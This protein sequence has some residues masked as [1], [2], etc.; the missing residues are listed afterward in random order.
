[1]L[2]FLETT[3]LQRTNAMNQKYPVKLSETERTQ[4]KQLI[5]SGT[6]PARKL[7]R[8]QILLKSD[9]STEGANW[10]YQVIDCV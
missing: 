9:S 2:P 7:R 5:S 8:A 4:L 3:L 1:M 10:N 6:A